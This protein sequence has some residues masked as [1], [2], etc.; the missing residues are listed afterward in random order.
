MIYYFTSITA[1]YLAKARVLGFSLKNYNANAKFVLA[2]SEPLP[3]E[4][5]LEK[6]PFDFVIESESLNDIG[7]KNNFFFKLSFLPCFGY[8][9]VYDYAFM[10]DYGDGAYCIKYFYNQHHHVS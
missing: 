3:S 2:I 1:N 7:N 10:V 9:F 4:I 6:E 8:G 5:N